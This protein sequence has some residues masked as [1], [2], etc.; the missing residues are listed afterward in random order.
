[1]SAARTAERRDA[2]TPLERTD[3]ACFLVTVTAVGRPAP[4]VRRLTLAAPELGHLVLLGPDEFFGLLMPRTGQELP[5][6]GVV[7]GPNPRP[8]LAGLPEEQRPDL[9]WYTVRAHRPGLGEVDVD[10][11]VHGDAGPGSAW[12]RRA[13]VGQVAAYQTGTACYRRGHGGHQVVVGDETAA[14]AVAA[15]LEQLDDDVVPHVFL[16]VP[17]V[18]E[19]LPGLP[20]PTRGSL[21]VLERGPGLPGSVLL[22]ALAAADLPALTYAWV[23]GEQALAAE[24]RRHLVHVRGMPRTAVYFCAYWVLGRPRG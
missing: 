1:M 4:H 13:R 23:A 15:I 14:P 3:H 22:P 20:A 12:V 2:A 7:R 18:R 16:E 5:D 11:V 17:S 8:V 19:D 21:T 6:L 9:R 24:A 10:V